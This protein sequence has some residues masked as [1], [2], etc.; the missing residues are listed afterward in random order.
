MAGLEC[1]DIKYLCAHPNMTDAWNHFMVVMDR[2]QTVNV[3]K[4]TIHREK[5]QE[6]MIAV[7]QLRIQ[8]KTAEDTKKLALLYNKSNFL[9][10]LA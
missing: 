9:N 6:G 3:R 5:E 4:V 10:G 2:E 1:N 8:K 7:Q